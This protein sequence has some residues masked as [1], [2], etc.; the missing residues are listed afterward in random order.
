VPDVLAQDAQV[1]MGFSVRQ[2]FVEDG[3]N[4]GAVGGRG[5]G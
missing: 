3:S 2:D 4:E 1:F 5:L